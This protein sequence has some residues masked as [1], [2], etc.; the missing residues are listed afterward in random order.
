M[1]T[2]PA[3]ADLLDLALR[4]ARAAGRFLVQER[5]ADLDV[6]ATK[7]SPTDVVTAMDRGSEELVVRT[8]RAERPDDGVLGEEGAAATGSTGVR[9][10]VDPIDGTVNYLYGLPEWAV[11][12][13][14]EVDG[15]VV[16]SVVAAPA[17]GETWTATRG[18]GAHLDG[19][20][21]RRGR[22]ADL[23]QALVATGFSYEA[24]HRALQ[25]Q[26]AAQVLPRVRDL[27][28]AGSAAL[29]LCGVAGGRHD[30]Y[31]ERGTHHWDVA[32]AALVA[33]EAGVRVGGLRGAP[34]SEELVLAA[35]DPLFDD[36]HALLDAAWPA[37][38]PA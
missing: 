15:E 6:A 26:V 33:R 13:A 35:A 20:P 7:T 25:A 17:L 10:V 37:S 4:A 16:A 12:I 5:P 31:F 14:A 18:G 21:L 38:W 29:D 11:S 23:G 19:R 30:A 22:G 34:E 32:A 2:A 9:W 3:P 24:R 8:L 1:S 36:L 27:R 28:R